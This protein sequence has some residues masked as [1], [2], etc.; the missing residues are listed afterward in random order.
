MAYNTLM[1]RSVT[2]E[3]DRPLHI[4]LNGC[5]IQIQQP[6]I[7]VI[8]CH[9]DNLLQKTLTAC[10]VY[11]D[12]VLRVSYMIINGPHTS[13]MLHPSSPHPLLTPR[14]RERE[15]ERGGEG[16]GLRVTTESTNH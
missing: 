12:R 6:V 16:G 9:I 11:L 1:G 7:H 3:G 10:N 13:I 4:T 14:E 5:Y 15:R 8:D 2:H